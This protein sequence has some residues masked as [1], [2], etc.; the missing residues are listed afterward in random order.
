M[1]IQEDR[2]ETQ[3]SIDALLLYNSLANELRPTA[4]SR[5]WIEASDLVT[6]GDNQ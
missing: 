4:L 6:T 2:E 3:S 1:L 5:W